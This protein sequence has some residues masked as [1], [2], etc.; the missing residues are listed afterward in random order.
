M[1]ATGSSRRAP[2]R[3]TSRPPFTTSTTLPTWATPIRPSQATCSPAGTV[4]AAR[5]CG[6][7]PARTSTVRRSCAPPRRTGSR[8]PSGATSSSRSRGSPSGSTWRSRTT[9]SSA[10]RRSGT[11]TAS[12]SSS[13][14]STTR[15]RSTR[16]ATRAR[17]AWAARSTRPTANCSTARESTRGRSCAR[18]T[19][20]RGDAQGGE[21]LLPALRVRPKLLEHYEAHPEFIQPES[22]RNEVVQ[23]VTAG[24]AGPVD[25]PLHLRLGHQGAVGRQARH[26]RVGRRAAQ[27]RHR[28]RLRRGPGEVR[29]DL[30]GRRAPGRQ[31]HPPLPR[32]D[33][34]RDADGQR[35]AAARAGRR[36]RLADGRRR[37]DVASPT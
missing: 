36:Q 32:G 11:P 1:A 2:R 3:T 37:E 4:S 23:F 17:T 27:L 13:R 15:V 12:R 25:L 10:P 30:P 33:L 8:P 18:S 24:P 22:A 34:A 29:R 26:L 31:G 21:L 20:A 19:S 6:T 35:P 14:T 9:T 16:A 28:G 5:R 7:S